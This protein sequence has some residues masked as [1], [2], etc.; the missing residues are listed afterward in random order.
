MLCNIMIHQRGRETS[1]DDDDDEDGIFE[2]EV[3]EV[4]QHG[5]T[6]FLSQIIVYKQR[7]NIKTTLVN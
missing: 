1:E 7:R 3:E 4:L 5:C 2:K 6:I